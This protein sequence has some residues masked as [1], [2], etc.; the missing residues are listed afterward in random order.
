MATVRRLLP[1][2]W[3]EGDPGAKVRVVLAMGLLL[4]A[5]LATVYVPVVYGRIVDV[6]APKDNTALLAIPI[7]LVIGY[8]LLRMGSAMFGELRDALFAKVQQ[9]AVRTAARRTFEHLHAVSL[10][11]HLDRQT[12]ALARAIDRGSQAIQSVLRLAVFNV[13]PTVIELLLVTAIIWH[14]FDWRFAAI[15]FGAVASYAAFTMSFAAWRSRI[16]RTMNDTDNDASTKALDSLL[17]YET[18]KYFGNEPH[19]VAR[20]DGALARYEQAAVRVQVS[21]NLLN[22]G[23]AFIIAGGLTLIMLLASREVRGGTMTVGQFVLVN[24]YL[25]Q[26]YQPLGFLG[27]VYMTIRQGLVDMEQMFR[28]LE[29]E[30][31][32]AD[33]PGATAL[34]AHGPAGE[35]RFEGVQFGYRPD[36][37]ILRGI[38][39]TV[40]AGRKLAIVGPTGAG[41]STI[42]R[43][44]FRFYDVTKGRICIDGQ[45]I[46]DVTQGSLR[47][48]IGVVPQDTVLFNDTIRY[49][50]AYGHV[51][52]TQ[53]QIEHAARLAQVHGFIASL[54]DGYDTRVGERGLKLSGGEKQ[55]VAI[56]RTILKDPRI[57]ILDEATSALD[58]RTEQDIQAALRAVAQHRTTLVIA[59]R[60]STVVDADEIIVL[61][62]G[63][64]AEHGRHAAL[65]AR[66]GLYARMWAL[67]AEQEMEPEI[68]D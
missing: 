39:F 62:D 27:M 7:G 37:T 60:L 40:P 23:Q 9:R 35:V 10:R 67:Q 48:A 68:A 45:D 22:I 1:Y 28:L 65:L 57:L 41:K 50:I 64:V 30:R 44:L 26:L 16:R 43:L 58:T 24:T 12:G 36:R 47:A 51:G 53:D 61:A 20:Y 8:G 13:V 17:N 54:P 11:F 29:V 14:L 49:N 25:M 31:E 21:L 5:K 55:R 56:A 32:I 66:D 2:L 18:V 15:T 46:R 59:H 3:P 42:S 19:E 63:R 33:R 34:A 52:A 4:L 38:D 6:L